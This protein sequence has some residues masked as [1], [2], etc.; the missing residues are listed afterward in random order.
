MQS[1]T[2]SYSSSNSF[3]STQHWLPAPFAC[4]LT[5]S[6]YECVGVLISFANQLAD[7]HQLSAIDAFGRHGH[8]I[9]LGKYVPQ[10]RSSKA[11]FFFSTGLSERCHYYTLSTLELQLQ[12]SDHLPNSP[13]LLCVESGNPTRS[14]LYVLEGHPPHSLHMY[15]GHTFNTATYHLGGFF[16]HNST[17]LDCLNLS[18]DFGQM[19]K[20]KPASQSVPPTQEYVASNLR[21]RRQ[22]EAYDFALCSLVATY[23]AASHLLSIAAL[24][25]DY[26][27]QAARRVYTWNVLWA[28]CAGVK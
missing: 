21:N 10:I 8:Y 24:I 26:R 2:L 16:S 1:N 22:K 28:L 9:H 27:G 11:T 20:G 18:C 5:Q 3:I 23:T 14:I 19:L 25:R 7:L 13:H 17:S 12:G 4:S 6:A 15:K